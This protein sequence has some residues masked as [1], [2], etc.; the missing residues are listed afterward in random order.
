V[1]TQTRHALKQDKLA[2]AA[3]SSASWVGEHRSGVL[4]WVIGIGAFLALGAA[5]LVWWNVR[6]SAADLALGHAIDLF[7]TPLAQPGEPAEKDV[8]TTTQA[9]D[10]EANREFVAVAHDFRW[11]PEA[12]KARYFAGVTYQELGQD[13]PAETELKAA[14]GS[15]SRNVANL[16][17]YALAGLYHQ[18]NRDSQAIDLYNEIAAKP[19]ETMAASV[20]QLALADLYV[21]E[22]KPDLAR[23]LWAKISAA[24]KTS[25]A[26]TIAQQKLTA[27]Q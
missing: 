4:N 22:G 19:S 18:T 5:A 15:S 13:G 12:T 8:Y 6:T 21:A 27:R 7:N 11:L 10:T 25:A 20:A 14:A 3:K 24:D 1:D 23:V 17:K 26:A 2:R 16:A 9:R